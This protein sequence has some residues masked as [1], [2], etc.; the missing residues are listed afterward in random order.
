VPWDSKRPVI[1]WKDGKWLGDIADGPWP[2]M[3]VD[4]AATRYPFLMNPEG[5]GRLFSASLVEGPFPEHYEPLE[6]PLA[7]NL[8]NGAMLNPAVRKFQG[9]MDKVAPCGGAEFP[10]IGST[11]RVTE[12]WQT[13]V[14]TRHTPWLLEAV[15]QMFVELSLEL[16][17]EKNIRPGDI[18]LV[19]SARGQVKAV[20]MPTMRL[21]PLVVDGKP[22]HMV[23]LPWCFGWL[24][25]EGGRGGDSANLLTPTIGDANTGIPESKAFLVNIEKV[26]GAA[27][28]QLS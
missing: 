10:Y 1:S 9:V 18:V 8:L 2:P 25:P 20:A 26:S 4:P 14:M 24:M 3:A 11:Y 16:A 21:K 12:H 28:L 15:P 23:G 7:A 5:L 6:S 19:K 27:G 13:G 22:V 17:E